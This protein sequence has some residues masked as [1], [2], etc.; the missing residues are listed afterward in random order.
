MAYSPKKVLKSTSRD[1]VVE[2]FRELSVKFDQIKALYVATEAAKQ[3][4]ESEARAAAA[5]RLAIQKSAAILSHSRL[6]A[7]TDG[8]DSFLRMTQDEF[9]YDLN[10]IAGDQRLSFPKARYSVGDVLVAFYY[11]LKI[12]GN[13]TVTQQ[14]TLIDQSVLSRTFPIVSELLYAHYRKLIRF[15]EADEWAMHCD[16]V[17]DLYD[18]PTIN[19]ADRK[20]IIEDLKSCWFYVVDGSGFSEKHATADPIVSNCS[21]AFLRATPRSGAL[22]L[23]VALLASLFGRADRILASNPMTLR[24][25]SQDLLKPLIV[26]TSLRQTSRLE[27]DEDVLTTPARS[28]TIVLAIAAILTLK[29][30]HLTQ[31]LCL[32]DPLKRKTCTTAC[33]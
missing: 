4:A 28:Q 3:S 7:S 23:F 33:G 11:H 17:L 14:L 22:N 27:C 5:A 24:T 29:I 10:L 6:Q 1:G 18:P 12:C 32:H 13:L 9:D 30:S 20:K 19:E 2:I 31:I 8:F 26:S 21:V 15:L 25:I 16:A